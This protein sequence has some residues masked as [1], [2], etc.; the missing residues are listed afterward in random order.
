VLVHGAAGGVG[1]IV[2]QLA[3]EAGAYVLGTGR[4]ADH[5]SALDLGA[6]EFVDLDSESL[7]D[8]GGVDLVFDVI[9]GE[10]LS[11]SAGL[12]RSGGAVVSIADTPPRPEDGMAIYFVVVADRAQLTELVQRV[13]EGRLLTVIG[14][15]ATLDDA[16]AA[17]NPTE[18]VRGK[19]IIR[20]RP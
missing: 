13:R 15:V 11:R 20:V 19:T 7:E 14:Q 6:N 8:A 2:T 3:R 16:V 10:V 9:G 18:R 4:A 12:V 1:S 5:Q 17:F